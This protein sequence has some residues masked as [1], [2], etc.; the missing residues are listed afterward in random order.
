M[1][2]LLFL[3]T[4]ITFLLVFIFWIISHLISYIAGIPFVVSSDGRT[5]HILKLLN[6]KPGEKI[7]DLG[8]GDGKLLFEIASRGS[9]A[10]GYEI[11][12]IAYILSLIRA[13]NRGL[14]NV[15]ISW[16]NFMKADLSKYDAVVIYGISTMMPRLEK[17]LKSELK[18]GARIVSNY[19]KFPN[20][21]PLKKER[22]ILLYKI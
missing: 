14:N 22:E 15:H 17:K 10:Y 21:K 16:A 18:P 3:A 6:P 20:L 9:I 4:F 1:L 8:S 13:K 5:R 19:F 2:L 11:N 7:V 12:P